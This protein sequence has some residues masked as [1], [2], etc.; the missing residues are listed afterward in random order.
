[1][2]STPGYALS[3]EWPSLSGTTVADK[4]A[5]LNAIT[6]AGPNIDVTV[7]QVAGY[8]LLQ[9]VYPT[10]AA[11]AQGSPNSTQPHDGALTAAK[12][13]MAWFTMPNPPDVRMS[14][15]AVVEEVTQMGNAMVAQEAA[16]P[17][18]TGFTQAILNGLLAL[19]QTT[20]SWGLANGFNGPVTEADV[21]N[22]GLT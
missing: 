1:M 15:A 4:L 8:L 9:G 6:V 11:F 18:S 20:I 16:S 22:A 10:I 12:S 14:Q 3:Q 7:Q 17:G 19:G 2:A 21:T 13:F 5:A